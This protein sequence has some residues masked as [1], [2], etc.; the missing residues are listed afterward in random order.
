MTDQHLTLTTE[1]FVQQA[2]EDWGKPDTNKFIFSRLQDEAKGILNDPNIALTVTNMIVE[3]SNFSS[4]QVLAYL[5]D[6]SALTKLVREAEDYL[7]KMQIDNPDRVG[8]SADEVQSTLEVMRIQQ[9]N[10]V[11]TGERSS[12]LQT[13]NAA[14]VEMR[15]DHTAHV[16]V[17]EGIT[18]GGVHNHE[19]GARKRTTRPVDRSN[20][21]RWELQLLHVG[22]RGRR[23]V[24]ELHPATF[25]V[26]LA[27]VVMFLKKL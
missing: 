16:G 4:L 23:A 10:V 25:F 12:S 19:N 5:S 6:Y 20:A 14:A 22:P 7:E 24:C 3:L 17:G 11:G 21:S 9:E 13:S 27:A 2:L 15:V 18:R 1:K 26:I 8:H